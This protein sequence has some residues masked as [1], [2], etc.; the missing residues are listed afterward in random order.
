MMPAKEQSAADPQPNPLPLLHEIDESPLRERWQAVTSS[1]KR[2]FLG[3]E[4]CSALVSDCIVPDKS[5]FEESELRSRAGFQHAS[6]WV[7]RK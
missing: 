2:L 6:G 1:A 7:F 3:A 4:R 5:L